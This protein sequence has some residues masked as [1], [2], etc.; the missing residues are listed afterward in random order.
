MGKNIFFGHNF[1]LCPIN[2]KRQI[3]HKFFF[4]IGLWPWP[5]PYLWTKCRRY[6][7]FLKVHFIIY[8]MIH[9]FILYYKEIYNLFALKNS[10]FLKKM[11]KITK[12]KKL[13]GSIKTERS[14]FAKKQVQVFPAHIKSFRKKNK[15]GEKNSYTFCISRNKNKKISTKLSKLGKCTYFSEPSYRSFFIEILSFCQWLLRENQPYFR[16]FGYDMYTVYIYLP[17]HTKNPKKVRI[18]GFIGK[19]NWRKS[20]TSTVG[21]TMSIF[22]C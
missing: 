5:W 18:W 8:L 20:H 21:G 4:E 11:L 14:I 2:G 7:F 22:A 15:K 17:S 13:W 1:S 10:K 9:C 19:K 16:V 6:I 3:F 12:S